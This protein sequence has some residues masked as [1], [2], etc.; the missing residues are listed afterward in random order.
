MENIQSQELKE[1][2]LEKNI[3]QPSNFIVLGLV[4]SEDVLTLLSYC[5]DNSL[6]AAINE[7]TNNFFDLIKKQRDQFKKLGLLKDMCNMKLVKLGSIP[8]CL[9]KDYELNQK[10]ILREFSYEEFEDLF[11]LWDKEKEIKNGD[12][13]EI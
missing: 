9:N 10:E 7:M 6:E 13:N 11:T 5:Y 4:S 1:T 2:I 12:N 8:I 3:N